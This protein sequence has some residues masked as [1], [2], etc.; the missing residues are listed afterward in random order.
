VRDLALTAH[1]GLPMVGQWNAAGIVASLVFAIGGV[2]IEAWGFA[3]R[4]LSG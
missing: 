2:A 4:D 1:Y 3:R